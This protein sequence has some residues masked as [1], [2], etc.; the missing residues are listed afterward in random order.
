MRGRTRAFRVPQLCNYGSPIR[1]A[2]L[3]SGCQL[4]GASFNNTN[5]THYADM[6]YNLFH[7]H[8]ILAHRL[9]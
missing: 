6:R 4:G 5:V 3:E 9:P 1:Q 8:Q 2:K 7:C